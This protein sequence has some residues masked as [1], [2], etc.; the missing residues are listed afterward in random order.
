MTISRPLIFSLVGAILIAV[1]FFATRGGATEEAAAPPVPAAPSAPAPSATA[2]TQA[3]VAPAAS[4]PG[5]APSASQ[6]SGS[7]ATKTKADPAAEA[8][9]GLE[10]LPPRVKRALERDKVVVFLFTQRDSADDSATLKGARSIKTGKGRVSVFTDNVGNLGDY[11][12]LVASVGVSRAPSTVIVNDD[13]E[14]RLLEGY[15][16]PGSLRQHVKDALR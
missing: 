12:Q 5:A 16:D 3:G 14:V 6:Q 1:T 11:G 15:V 8:L 2:P 10:G 7:E 4:K 13:G 9:A